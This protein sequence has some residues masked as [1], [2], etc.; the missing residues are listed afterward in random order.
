MI[1]FYVHAL[2][3]TG[4]VRNV[5]I[6]AR[7]LADRGRDV[8][9]V[10]ALPGGDSAGLPHRALLSGAGGGRAVEKLRA[11]HALR[12]E[13]RRSGPA[14]LIS[15]GNHDHALC[16]AA[17]RG[18][19]GLRR[20]YRISNDLVRAAPGAPASR[21]GQWMRAHM[22]RR[23]A[24]DADHI[25]CV[26]PTLADMP[27]WAAAA[28]DGRVTVIPNGIDVEAVRNRTRG[29]PPHRWMA[30]E[31]P[32][33]L[34]IGRLARQKN[35]ETLLIAFAALR[36]RRDARL[37]ILG[38]SRDQA[39]ARLI[40]QAAALGV[41]DDVDLPGVVPDVLPWLDHAAAFILPSWWEGSPN[42]LLEAMAVGLPV[43]AS[44]SAGNAADLL[45]HG[46]FGRLVDPADAAGMAD[47]LALQ[48]DP[49]TAIRPGDR[50]ARFSQAAC[51][52]AWDALLARA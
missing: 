29:A 40:A 18:L 49:A 7:D 19:A 24:A 46:R 15:A 9:I 14:V 20:I 27:A 38:D 12:R 51:C 44:R 10:T 39:R 52:G 34:A 36:A 21:A 3:A 37:I 45:D 33:I 28:R 32:V 11:V 50:I 2:A 17:S 23:L 13:L 22:A 42:V 43:V 30:G 5:R 35:L 16:W 25:V 31:A 4:V 48:I 8:R 6:L 47:A 41:A 26:S 1:L